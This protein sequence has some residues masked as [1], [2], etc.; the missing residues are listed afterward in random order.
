MISD[1][2]ST[3]TTLLPKQIKSLK[4]FIKTCSTNSPILHKAIL[5]VSGIDLLKTDITESKT[6]LTTTG[7]KLKQL[8]KT[9]PT[10]NTKTKPTP[11]TK[12]KPTPN[13]KTKPTPNTKTKPTTS[14]KTKG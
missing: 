5:K 11:N 6:D 1:I 13:K 7:G 2:E 10:P 4:K 9:K 14:E 12:T 8:S 3:Y